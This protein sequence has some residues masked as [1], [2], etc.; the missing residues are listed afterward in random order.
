[1]RFERWSARRALL[2]VLVLASLVSCGGR[3]TPAAERA[4]STMRSTEG[5]NA[6]LVVF[7][8]SSLLGPFE[9]LG[10][11]FRSRHPSVAVSFNFAGSAQL[12]AQLEQGALADVAAFAD[13]DNMRRAQAAGLI[14]GEPV[15]FARNRL[16]LVVPASNPAGIERLAD[17]ARPGVKVVLAHENV[18]AGRYA[19]TMLTRASQRPDYGPDFAQRVLANVVS[20]GSERQAGLG[21]SRTRRGRCRYRLRHRHRGCWPQRPGSRDPERP[22]RDR[23]LSDRRGRGEPAASAG[24]EFIALVRSETGQQLLAQYG[25]EPVSRNL[26]EPGSCG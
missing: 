3:S 25:F 7:A 23:L 24:G 2:L 26:S 16:A 21:Q 10:E 18:P 20:Q 13:P 6:Q 4:P 8:A 12:V 11:A 1:V 17:L 19:R 5:E 22:E 14:R 15:V 9:Q